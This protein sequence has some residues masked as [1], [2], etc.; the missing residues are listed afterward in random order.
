MNPF[1]QSDVDRH[2]IWEMLVERDIQAFL[3]ADWGTVQEDF[4]A[5]YFVGYA[6]TSNP[7]HWRIAFPTLDAYRAEWMR[8]AKD[9]SSIK[10]RSIGLR[11]FLHQTTVLRDVEIRHN[12]AMAHKKFDGRAMTE[13]GETL[14]LNWQ[15]IYWLRRFPSGWKI[16]G[17]LGFL[18]NPMPCAAGKPRAHISLPAGASQHVTAGPYSPSLRVSAGAL[19]AISG[20][21]PIDNDGR[22]IGNSIQ[23]QADQTLANCSQQLASAGASFRDVFKVM[24][25]LRDM[26]DWEAFNEVYRRH[27]RPPYPVRTA[28]QAVLWGDI[29]VEIDMLAISNEERT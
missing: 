15:T 9:F 26:A 28:I 29:K 7:D 18:P 2:E 20:Q 12:R 10:L 6:G 1:P 11:E 13:S 25:Y 16:T 19:I 3:T 21:G 24:V 8:Q 5:D 27:F 22:I 17:F 14:I 23:E 4:A